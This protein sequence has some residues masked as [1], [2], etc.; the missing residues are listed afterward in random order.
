MGAHQRWNPGTGRPLVIYE[1][2]GVRVVSEH[3]PPCGSELAPETSAAERKRLAEAADRKAGEAFRAGDLDRAFRLV[4]DARC[5]DPAGRR[6]GPAREADPGEGRS[7]PGRAAAKGSGRPRGNRGRD[8]AM[9]GLECRSPQGPVRPRV[10]AMPRARNCGSARPSA[11]GAGKGGICMSMIVIS[12]NHSVREHVR[13]LRAYG[14]SH[15]E[16]AA[17]AGIGYATIWEAVNTPEA[18][19]RATASAVLSVG[20]RDVNLRRM[21]AGGSMWRLR[22]SRPCLSPLAGLRGP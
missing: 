22:R 1:R 13:Q 4:T 11:G 15:R 8:A 21:P 7:A 5:L 17:A 18:I 16:I 6:P 9:G 2:G 12:S 19:S 14:A 3:L 20:P 10:A